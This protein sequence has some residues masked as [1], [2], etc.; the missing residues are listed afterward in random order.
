MQLT[1]IADG[2]EVINLSG[3]RCEPDSLQQVF[4]VS[5]GVVAV[6]AARAAQDGLLDLDE[7]LAEYWPEFSRPATRTVTARM[8]L[9]HSSG[10]CAVDRAL[11]TAQ[12]VAGELDDAVAH[13]DPFW[14]PGT[15]HGYHAF[16]FGALMDGIFLHRLGERVTAF[17][18]SR[19]IQPLGLDMSFGL[20]AADESRLVPTTF[21]DPVLTPAMAAGMSSPGYIA[22]GSFAEINQGLEPFF[23][24]DDVR[25]ANWPAMSLVAGARDLARLFAATLDDSQGERLISQDSLAR[26]TKIR[27]DGFDL[28]LGYPTRFGTGFQLP[29]THLPMFGPRSFGHV[30]ASGSLVVADPDLGLSFAFTTTAGSFLIGASDYA[31]ILVDAVRFTLQ[32]A[33]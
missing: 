29:H 10:I 32:N 33:R 12:L 22:D 1:V 26:A 5:K 30:G 24:R 17:A 31:L 14:E 13:Q 6:A 3:G 11:T 18:D 19:L 23:A 9:S 2:R 8:V 27:S 25:R 20:R 28:T 7:P 16:T 15:R 21:T 4:S